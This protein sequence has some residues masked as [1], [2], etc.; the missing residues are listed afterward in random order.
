[1]GQMQK[2]S[3]GGGGDA[4]GV[5]DGGGNLSSGHALV[6]NI[7]PTLALNPANPLAEAGLLG[8]GSQT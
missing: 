7:L 5:W 4:E 2:V 8:R 6:R 3:G 1:M